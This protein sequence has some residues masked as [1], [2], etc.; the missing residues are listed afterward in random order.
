MHSESEM[1]LVSWEIHDCEV[2]ET[3]SSGRKVIY[4]AFCP[5]LA[6]K[7]VYEKKQYWER[8]TEELVEN[9]K[10]A[11][12]AA[13]EISSYLSKWKRRNHERLLTKR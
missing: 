5:F 6:A 13:M 10:K 9:L 11:D 8:K 7:L 3:W 2:I 4:Y 1:T 12:C